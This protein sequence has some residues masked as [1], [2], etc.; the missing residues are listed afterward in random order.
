MEWQEVVERMD[1]WAE[2]VAAPAWDLR[3]YAAMLFTSE[4]VGYY[5]HPETLQPALR[6]QAPEQ[7]VTDLTRCAYTV[8][9]ALGGKEAAVILADKP[10]DAE[11]WVKVAASPTVRRLGETLNFFP[12]QYPGGIPNH[13]SPL[14]A[15][16]TSG[17]I[18]AGLGWGTGKVLGKLLPEGYG[19]NLGRTGAIVGGALG[20]GPG[21]IWGGVNLANDKSL[22]DRWPH[23]EP[24]QDSPMLSSRAMDGANAEPLP[25]PTPNT[26]DYLRDYLD[27][28]Q[29]PTAVR[30]RLDGVSL[31]TR[32]KRALDAMEKTAFGDFFGGEPEP[33][34]GTP[35][36]VNINALG[37]TLWQLGARPNLTAT[38]M[39]ALY[40]AQQM[41]DERSQPGWATGHQLGQF[42]ENMGSD[43]RRGPLVGMALNAVTDY[44]TGLGAGALANATVGTPYRASTIGLGNVVLGIVRAVV[45]RLFG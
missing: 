3:K 4:P 24:G 27:E 43:Y 17:L 2:R 12:G 18:G 21:A 30:D 13:P 16:L 42:A 33:A 39:G 34:Q 32:F 7:A 37:Q 9:R 6:A 8:K 45:P 23:P 22:L 35:L 19:D 1:D 5:L 15:M 29:L 25:A 11:P 41:P 40:A 31:G 38:T 36:D 10:F 14:A 20:A 28:M 44:A 26:Y